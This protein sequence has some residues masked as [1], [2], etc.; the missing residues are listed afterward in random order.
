[1]FTSKVI[2]GHSVTP[3]T[4]EA[5]AALG[6]FNGEEGL[7]AARNM[8]SLF[9]VTEVDY[10][11]VLEVPANLPD[12]QAALLRVQAAMMNGDPFVIDALW[13]EF[14]GALESAC[15]PI[16]EKHGVST[17]YGLNVKSGTWSRREVTPRKQAA[18]GVTVGEVK[19]EVKKL[20]HIAT[21]GATKL[22]AGST[23]KL[24]SLIVANVTGNTF[25]E[26][27]TDWPH[28]GKKYAEKHGF[29]YTSE[30]R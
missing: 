9:T 4:V 28:T 10:C 21:K 11:Q 17:R 19:P 15:K 18:E 2:S 7:K 5:Q 26:I 3:K 6:L 8:P 22:E 20:V 23:N 30:L 29:I 24:Y 13:R 25:K 14:D 1:M 12:L 27:A 16:R